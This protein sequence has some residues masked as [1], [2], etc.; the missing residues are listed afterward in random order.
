MA[1]G[2]FWLFD[3][4]WVYQ[5]IESHDEC[6]DFHPSTDL[7]MDN[8]RI[9]CFCEW[10]IMLISYTYICNINMYTFIYT[11]TYLYIPTC[12]IQMYNTS[13]KDTIH[14]ALLYIY[15]YIYIS[16]RVHALK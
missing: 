15:I 2:I 10:T 12:V 14:V 13:P 6:M 8:I 9:G 4:A 5:A 16:V 3:V 11:H 7:G 1:W